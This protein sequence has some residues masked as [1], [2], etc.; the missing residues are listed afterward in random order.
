MGNFSKM[1]FLYKAQ[2]AQGTHQ[3]DSASYYLYRFWQEAQNEEQKLLATANLFSFY[4][5]RRQCDSIK[6]YGMA[7][8]FLAEK[9]AFQQERERLQDIHA[10][11]NFTR[12]QRTAELL[13][14]KA[15]RL[16]LSVLLLCL[17]FLF[18]SVTCGF[19]LWQRKIRRR[20]ETEKQARMYSALMLQYERASTRLKETETLLK[21]Y[22]AV[23]EERDHLKMLQ[24]GF[25][26]NRE[27]LV[28]QQRQLQVEFE[29]AKRLLTQSQDDKRP[30][31]EWLLEENL[32]SQPVVKMLHEHALHGR[33]ADEALLSRMTSLVKIC[34]P[35]FVQLLDSKI[36]SDKS[37][38]YYICILTK[39]RFS[40]SEIGVL[41]DSEPQSLN[42]LRRHLHFKLFGVKGGAKDFDE[43]IRLYPENNIR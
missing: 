42:G 34:L 22:D 5:D 27:E 14:H 40:L 8:Q 26:Q 23:K 35:N 4:C 36:R 7:F 15:E 13:K 25:E 32:M 33:T 3:I 41:I 9:K 18:C 21:E 19:F 1:L 16:R 10:L 17:L 28:R 29:K 43:K 12:S 2:Y 20:H 11:Y 37:K 38:V 6:K 39:L 30:P 24:K 31:E